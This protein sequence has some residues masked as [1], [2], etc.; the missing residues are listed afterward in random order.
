MSSILLLTLWFANIDDPNA[1][2]LDGGGRVDRSVTPS[3]E[4][5]QPSRPRL[6]AAAPGE[7]VV[8]VHWRDSVPPAEIA[9]FVSTDRNTLFEGPPLAQR[10]S[11]NA[12]SISGLL[13]G[14]PVHLGLAVVPSSPGGEP[15]PVP[16]VLTVVPGSPIHVDPG[17]DP[18]LADGTRDHPYASPFIAALIAL[19]RGGGN[20]WMRQ[21]IYDVVGVPIGPGVHIYGGFGADFAL[22]ERDPA[23]ATVW[24]APF[25]TVLAQ[26][27]SQG[28][29]AILDGLTLDGLGIG[30]IGLDVVESSVE[31]RCVDVTR[32]TDRGIRMRNALSDDSFRATLVHSSS[33]ANGADGVNVRGAFD[34]SVYDCSFEGNAQEGF[35]LDD[36]VA[37]PD[38]TASLEISDCRFRNN[39]TDGIDADLGLPLLPGPIGGRFSIR[40]DGSVFERNLGDGLLIDI[41][42]EL[43]P[44]WTGDILVRQCTARANRQCGIRVDADGPATIALH[45]VLAS[46]NAQ[47]GIRVTSEDV[48]GLV[49]V[50]TTVAM[51]NRG[52]G[53]RAEGP[54]GGAGLRTLAASHCILM[55]NGEAGITSRDVEATATSSIGHLQ[56]DPWPGTTTFG[57]VLTSDS[58]PA[59]VRAPHDWRAVVAASTDGVTLANA[60]DLVSG[61]IVELD[62]DGIARRIVQV[63][64]EALVLDP[65]PAP[66]A[67]PLVLALFR[68]PG[69]DEDFHLVPGCGAIGAGITA[70]GDRLWDAGIYGAPAAGPPGVVELVDRPP[71]RPTMSVPP[72]FIVVAPEQAIEIR[73]SDLLGPTVLAPGI[74]HVVRASGEAVGAVLIP[75]GD[76]LLI[77]PPA[78]GWPADVRRVELN[79]GIESADRAPSAA[80]L[81]LPLKVL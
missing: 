8:R 46:A 21:G 66:G 68:R 19:L 38:E 37:L 67:D 74:V 33:S 15:V 54:Q 12:L 41:D 1:G 64:G 81:V 53:M 23:A 2:R 72:P 69:V 16:P 55:G 60:R 77:F 7:G 27:Q 65:A 76:R 45:R 9:L 48:P 59:F 28:T 57:S 79:P 44:A 52:A 25:A 4:P 70:P 10:M 40:I 34:L 26:V 61:A 17:A 49:L 43:A 78:G 14:V 3:A 42:Y 62:D 35:E 29:L 50:S 36:L 13:D 56:H 58:A 39:G 20:V 30:T 47:D 73:F 22:E 18:S 11:G 24:R 75:E 63:S 31:L 32:F 80:P 5:Y 6:I 51:G 71:F